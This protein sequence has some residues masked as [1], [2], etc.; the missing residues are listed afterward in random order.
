M[1]KAPPDRSAD[2]DAYLTGLPADQRAALERLRA[3]I[4]KAAPGTTQGISYRMPV[5]KLGTTP[6]VG[7]HAATEHC[8]FHLMSTETIDGFRDELAGYGLGKGTV[9]FTPERPLPVALVRRL[10]RARI[11]EV[12]R[13]RER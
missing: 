7:F 11:A 2:V 13:G 4:A 8:S 5:F 6:L 10:V 1:P 9:R 12:E 3:T